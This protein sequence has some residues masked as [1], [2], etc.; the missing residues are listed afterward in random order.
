VTAAL[1]LRLASLAAFLQWAAHTLLFLRARPRNG[2]D[3]V[4]VVAAMKSQRF[5]FPG[6]RRSY[7]DFYLGYGLVAAL[8]CLV[9]AILLLQLAGG[10]TA[11]PGLVRSI[12]GLVLAF[13]VAHLV[14]AARFFF[15]TPMVPDAVI[16]ALLGWVVVMLR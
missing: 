12:A 2:P 4:A 6:A 5:P 7:W 16:A 14:L 1:V 11:A 10:V 13:N 15:V 8:V 9:E 3:E